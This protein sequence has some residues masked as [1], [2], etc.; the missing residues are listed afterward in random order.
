MLII[1]YHYTSQ[2]DKVA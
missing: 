1:W 2:I